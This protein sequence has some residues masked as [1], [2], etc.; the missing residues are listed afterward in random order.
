MSWGSLWRRFWRIA[1]KRGWLKK[2]LYLI[3]AIVALPMFY[4]LEQGAWFFPIILV[5]SSLMAGNYFDAM[6]EHYKRERDKWHM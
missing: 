5:I 2:A 4:V 3:V 1:I 6:K